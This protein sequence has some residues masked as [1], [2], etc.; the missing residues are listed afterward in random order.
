MAT[1]VKLNLVPG[2]QS[3]AEQ[4]GQHEFQELIPFEWLL[5]VENCPAQIFLQR[6]LAFLASGEVQ[7]MPI[8]HLAP[9]QLEF[10][11]RPLAGMT[12][13]PVSEQDT[14]NIQK[15]CRDRD[16]SFHLASLNVICEPRLIVSRTKSMALDCESSR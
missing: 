12:T 5:I 16:I 3:S 14:A 1:I 6:E 10:R 2:R 9:L 8:L 4:V 11:R 15:Q 7:P 13:Q